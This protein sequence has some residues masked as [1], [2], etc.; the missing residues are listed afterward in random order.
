MDQDGAEREPSEKTTPL[1]FVSPTVKYQFAKY[2]NFE[3]VNIAKMLICLFF[4]CFNLGNCMPKYKQ[5]F[6][7]L[8]AV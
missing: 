3:N 7:I 5:L 4:K 1:I 2:N 8:F 6:E